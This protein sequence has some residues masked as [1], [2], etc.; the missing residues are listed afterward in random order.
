MQVP[1]ERQTVTNRARRE[2]IVAATIEVIASEGYRAAT[3]HA[4]AARAGIKSTR[5]ISYH[6]AGRDELIEAVVDS[7]LATVRSFMSGRSAGPF[8]SAG[9][10][11]ESAIRTT[12]ALNSAHGSSMQALMSIF[13]EHHPEGGWASYGPAEESAAMSPIQQIL[14]DGQS[15]GEFTEFDTS[16]MAATVQR[17]LDGIAYLLRTHP[18]LDLEHYADELVATFRRATRG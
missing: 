17:S 16:I 4:I 18:D 8:D 7:V 14:T 13:L 12:V 11:L 6:F 9:D 2:Q 5:T 1:T 3:F 15:A 10:A